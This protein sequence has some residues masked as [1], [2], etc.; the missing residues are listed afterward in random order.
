MLQFGVYMIRE[1][2]FSV[3]WNIFM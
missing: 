3:Q 2:H 1:V